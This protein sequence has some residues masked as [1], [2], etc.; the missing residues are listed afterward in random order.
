MIR[1]SFVS[2]FYILITAVSCVAQV[3]SWLWANSAS[4]NSANESREVAVSNNGDGFITGSFSSDTIH[5]GSNTFI[6]QTAPA[7]TYDIFVA[8]YSAYGYLLWV[9][10]FGGNHDDK[11]LGIATDDSGN[12]YITGAFGSD[13]ITFGS[14]TL[15]NTGVG[16]SW[17]VFVVKLDPSGNVLWARSFAGTDTDSG[18]DVE[19]DPSG[20]CVITGYYMSSSVSFD[21]YTLTSSSSSSFPMFIAKL[22]TSGNVIWV[23]SAAGTGGVGIVPDA[24]KLDQYG[25]CF[26]SGHFGCTG[27]TIGVSVISSGGN[28][29]AFI[30]KYDS[31]GNGTWA[32]AIDGD[33]AQDIALDSSGHIYVTGKF[34]ASTAVF[35]STTLY[36]SSTLNEF[37][38]A[39]YDLSGNPIWAR[40][41]AGASNDSGHSLCIDS[42]GNCYVTGIFGPPAITFGSI[43]VSNAGP[44]YFDI[45]VAG[46]DTAGNTI[47]ATGLGGLGGDEA[48]C[49]ETN[50]FGDI[51]LTGFIGSQ[52]VIF[53]PADT[54]SNEFDTKIGDVF[55]AKTGEGKTGLPGIISENNFLNI[56]PNPSS[57]IIY[58]E[59]TKL[60][61]NT[62]LEIFDAQGRLVHGT[63]VTE[64]RT[65][66]DL[67]LFEP[68]L[69]C[70]RIMCNNELLATGKLVTE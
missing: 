22:D 58:F 40:S 37:F 11:S 42:N 17:D 44:Q 15:Y 61:V 43:T 27:L 67:S 48:Y 2:T 21:S 28:T 34:Y 70:W 41:A 36:N 35:G 51:Y 20:N 7:G 24:L 19:I 5:F 47:W 29:Y 62:K 25:N 16:W 32:T 69:F 23:R 54:L 49:I 6:N 56:F 60:N 59:S 14:T 68:G 65:I 66:V 4:G 53:A 46:Y 64:P 50:S 55:V 39:K 57:G 45:F 52:N 31:N 1:G 13:T 30:A 3:P 38:L 33:I 26:L 9:V 18:T 12:C 10:T 8:K 63:I